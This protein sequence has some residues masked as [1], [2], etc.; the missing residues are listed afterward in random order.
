MDVKEY[1]FS[2]DVD[3]VQFYDHQYSHHGGCIYAP[4]V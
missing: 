2:H 3:Y 1:E 4:G